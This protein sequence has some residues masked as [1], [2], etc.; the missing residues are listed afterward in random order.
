MRSHVLIGLSWQ[1]C[2]T[3]DVP[4]LL[5]LNNHWL[6]VSVRGRFIRGGSHFVDGEAFAYLV[7]QV[8][9]EV[10]ALVSQD[11]DRRTVDTENYLLAA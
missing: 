10:S 7:E 5:E 4:L 8:T 2:R 3:N 6:N 1:R 9:F 11:L